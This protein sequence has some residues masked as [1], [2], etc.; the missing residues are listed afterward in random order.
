MPQAFP[1]V[2]PLSRRR[3]E[4]SPPMTSAAPAPIMRPIRTYV[5]FRTT[6]P[7]WEMMI[8]TASARTTS[9]QTMVPTRA[10][11]GA[12]SP[13]SAVSGSEA[14]KVSGV[15]EGSGLGSKLLMSVS[16]LDGDGA[17]RAVDLQDQ[18]G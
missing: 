17:D 2:G 1:V 10:E 18:P 8:R 3:A 5:P 14:L 11:A 7:S 4:S 6:I 16:F 15:E 12:G 9:P 13:G